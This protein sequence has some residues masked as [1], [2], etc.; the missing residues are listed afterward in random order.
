MKA[1][2]VIKTSIERIVY[3]PAL[4]KKV[5][6]KSGIPGLDL[7]VAFRVVSGL[8]SRAPERV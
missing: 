7:A 6:L 1:G 4:L 8:F 2:G 5:P 3:T